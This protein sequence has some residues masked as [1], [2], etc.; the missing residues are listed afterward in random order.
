M[1]GCHHKP[2]APP[3]T[4]PAKYKLVYFHSW[5]Q[6]RSAPQSGHR[7]LLSRPVS[8]A[9]DDTLTPHIYTWLE[10]IGIIMIFTR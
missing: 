2:P 1:A 7:Q 6:Q 5:L 10:I 8:D 3:A 4:R 9:Y